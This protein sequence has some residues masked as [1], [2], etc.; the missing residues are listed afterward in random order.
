MVDILMIFHVGKE[1]HTKIVEAQIRDRNSTVHIF[2]VND[3]LL[4]LF[5]LLLTVFKVAFFLGVYQ[6]VIAG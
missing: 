4:Q 2:K 5:E 3:F 6:I 1:I